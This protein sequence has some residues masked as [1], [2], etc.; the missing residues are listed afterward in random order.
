VVDLVLVTGVGA[1]MALVVVVGLV[2]ATVVGIV[3]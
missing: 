2:V 3:V 1:V